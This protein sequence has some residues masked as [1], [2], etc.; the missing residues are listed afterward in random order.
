[1]QGSRSGYNDSMKRD[2]WAILMVFVLALALIAGTVYYHPRLRGLVPVTPEDQAAQ[3][4]EQ[5]RFK[6][7]LRGDDPD[8]RSAL[9][10]LGPPAYDLVLAELKTMQQHPERYRGGRGYVIFF[11]VMAAAGDERALPYLTHF[12]SDPDTWVHHY[13]LLSRE[14]LEEKLREIRL[15]ITPSPRP[16]EPYE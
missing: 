4:I 5:V 8:Y 12:E 7:A 2:L 14:D 11:D 10:K 15:G 3:I 6:E 9:L 13:A 16:P 1:M